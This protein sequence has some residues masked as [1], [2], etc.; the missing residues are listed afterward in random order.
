MVKPIGSPQAFDAA[1]RALSALEDF[2][3]RDQLV[4]GGWVAISVL[5]ALRE[6]FERTA[7]ERDALCTETHAWLRQEIE[8][9]RFAK[10]H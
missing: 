3:P 4:A 1:H 7:A 9:L 2:E 10:S 6:R 5:G 8:T